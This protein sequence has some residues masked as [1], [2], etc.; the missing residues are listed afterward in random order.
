MDGDNSKALYL[1]S[2]ANKEQKAW[3]EAL[4]DIVAAIKLQPNDKTLRSHYNAVKAG[5][6]KWNAERKKI[7]GSFFKEGVYVD[8]NLKGKYANLPEFDPQNVQ[9]FMEIS[10]GEETDLDFQKGKVV[11]ELFDKWVPKTVENFRKQCQGEMGEMFTYRKNKFH[12]LVGK[13]LIQGGDTTN[14]DGSGGTS[15]YGLHFD[16]EQVWFPHKFK[17]VLSMANSGPHT[18]GSQFFVIFRAMHNLNE[19]HTVFGR[20]ISGWDILEKT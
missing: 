13:Q 7:F 9:V 18:N 6:D 12:R 16:D 3:T 1:R 14:G 15:I 8:K 2:V 10:I 20:V 4:E 11:F 5:Y 17:G 19:K